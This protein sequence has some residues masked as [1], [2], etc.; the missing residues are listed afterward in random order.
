[1]TGQFHGLV[2]SVGIR[3][4]KLNGKEVSGAIKLKYS[5]KKRV[6]TLSSI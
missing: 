1:M 5:V 4:L 6:N 2:L 3:V